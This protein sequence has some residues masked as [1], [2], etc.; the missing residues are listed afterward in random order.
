MC[1]FAYLLQFISNPQ[2][3]TYGA[4]TVIWK[5]AQSDKNLSFLKRTFP[6][7]VGQGDPLCLL[8][9]FSSCKQV[10][11]SWSIWCQHFSHFCSLCWWFC[12]FQATPK[13]SAEVQT[14][15]LGPRKQWSPLWRKYVAEVSLVQ[16]WAIVKWAWVQCE[17]TDNIYS[18]RCL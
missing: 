4:F 16:A 12:C 5:Y 10:S 1:N 3:K 11:F 6:A 18:L 17:W 13:H 14:S 15:V 2:I 9:Q 7:E 8:L